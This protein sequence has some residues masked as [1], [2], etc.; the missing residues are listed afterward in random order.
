VENVNGKHEK[1]GST[2]GSAGT[3][4]CYETMDSSE[5]QEKAINYRTYQNETNIDQNGGT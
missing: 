3:A 1:L 5:K 4:E 2:G